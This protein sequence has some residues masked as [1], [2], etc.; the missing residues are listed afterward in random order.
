[1]ILK[2]TKSVFIKKICHMLLYSLIEFGTNFSLL[3]FVQNANCWERG[4]NIFRGKWW[5]IEN[6]KNSTWK[7]RIRYLR[8]SWRVANS[9]WWLIIDK[10]LNQ[11]TYRQPICQTIWGDIWSQ[12]QNPLRHLVASK[13][14]NVCVSMATHT[15]IGHHF[16]HSVDALIVP[17]RWLTWENSQLHV[18]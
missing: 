16:N 8:P 6:L 10:E 4:T 14:W 9:R 17:H 13:D 18:E 15:C 7:V 12:R 2:L 1:M 11:V 3:R 5:K